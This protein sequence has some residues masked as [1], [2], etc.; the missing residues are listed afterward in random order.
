[1]FSD[2]KFLRRL[3]VYCTLIGILLL[4]LVI[5]NYYT[6]RQEFYYWL[7]PDDHSKIFT[8]IYKDGTWRRYSGIQSNPERINSYMLLLQAYFDNPKYKTFVDFGCG[9]WQFMRQINIPDDK[10]YICY[11]TVQDLVARNRARY[12]KSNVL[13]LY[14]EELSE[15]AAK[16]LNADMLIVKDVLQYWPNAD[17][18]YFMT[19]I[20]PK[21]S[22]AL[23]TNA[24]SDRSSNLNKDIRLGESRPLDLTKSPFGYKHLQPVLYNP[25]TA[26]QVYLYRKPN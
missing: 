12:G 13:F 1:M 7:Y 8:Q 16:D 22:T 11:E 14:N 24:F 17:I 4:L 18:K 20:V 10:V 26:Q 2:P 9:D 6:Y 25:V 23:I 15:F 21:F 19:N 3:Q 5:Q